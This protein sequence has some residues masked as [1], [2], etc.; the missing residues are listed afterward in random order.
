MILDRQESYMIFG[1]QDY[2]QMG[3]TLGAA[4]EDRHSTG[5][6]WRVVVDN[7]SR[8]IISGLLTV[9]F[10]IPACSGMLLGLMWN[11]PELLLLAGGI[12]FAIAGPAYGAMYD[13]C[14][15]AYM[16]YPGRW[17]ERYCEVFKREW[18]HCLIPGAI[19]GLIIATVVNV[20]M[21]IHEGNTVDLGV[22]LCMVFLVVVS[23]SIL[24][25]F[26]TQRMLLDLDLM[27]TLKNSWLMFLMHPLLALGAAAIRIVYWAL[28]L[29]LYPYSLVFLLVLSVWF[30][31]L[32]TVRVVYGAL[33]D[34]LQLDQRFENVRSEQDT[35]E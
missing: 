7:L 21:N 10:S 13:A 12:G 22:I 33:D 25:Y 29:I 15:M 34:A 16:G 8:L 26:W 28:M 1:G 18:R 14:V 2:N 30:P 23:F 6:T 27:Q 35:M 4:T 11:R 24:S 9:V 19:M 17:W 3:G 32:M 5:Y 31:A 20:F